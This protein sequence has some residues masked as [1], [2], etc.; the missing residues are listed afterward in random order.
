MAIFPIHVIVSVFWTLPVANS[1][2]IDRIIQINDG[3]SRE[4]KLLP[5]WSIVR[6]Q[7]ICQR[8]CSCQCLCRL[9]RCPKKLLGLSGVHNLMHHVHWGSVWAHS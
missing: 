7:T 4:N 9:T 5:S 1:S 3:A 8:K 6:H 2:I